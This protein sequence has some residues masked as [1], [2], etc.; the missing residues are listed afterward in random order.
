MLLATISGKLPS[1]ILV[2]TVFKTSLK[3]RGLVLIPLLTLSLGVAEYGAFVQVLAVTTLLVNLFLLGLD[4]GFV[5]YIYTVD[6]SR[7][8]FSSLVLLTLGS[9]SV[10]A[11]GVFLGADLLALYTLRAEEFALLFA[12]GALYVPIEAL[13]RMG[14]GYFWARRRIKLYS[15]IEAIDVYLSILAVAVVIIVADGTLEAAYLAFVLTHG[16]VAI[17][18]LVIVIWDGGLGRPTT[19]GLG[20]CLSLSLGIMGT[21]LSQSL[22]DKL[23][24]LLLGFFVGASAVG[25]YSVAY[26]VANV[27]YLY[28]RPLT[29]SFF[30]EFSKLWTDGEHERI[31]RYSRTGIRYLLLLGLPSVAGF[32]LIGEQLIALI[33]TDDVARAGA[34]PLVLISGGV[35]AKGIGELYTQL[36]FAADESRLPFLVQTTTLAANGVLNVLLIPEYQVLGAALATLFTFAGGAAVLIF[37]FRF[38]FAV[39]PGWSH[40]AKIGLAAAIMYATFFTL[41]LP[42]IAV[43]ASAPIVYLLVLLGLGELGTDELRSLLDGIR[44]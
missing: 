28:F 25:V 42:W 16:C 18:L 43:L 36:Y 11:I 37:L 19:D 39:S 26:K 5:R 17:G 38:P 20:E 3:I 33:S 40:V 27:L 21:G 14:R 4:S 32:A 2:T 6:D 1:D 22:L 15:A 12:L 30:P 13:F 31:S 10:A 24:R 35:L 8:L 34:L 29:I 44:S 9:S 23:D 41:A 7:G